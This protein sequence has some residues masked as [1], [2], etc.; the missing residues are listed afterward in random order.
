MWLGRSIQAHPLNILWHYATGYL[1]DFLNQR[2]GRVGWVRW[3]HRGIQRL[4]RLRMSRKQRACVFSDRFELRFNEAFGQVLRGCADTSRWG[5]RKHGGQT[6]MTP[7]LM[8]GLEE[9]H[10]LG[11]AHSFEAWQNGQL[12]GGIWGVQIGGLITMSSM[13]TTVSN[14]TRFAMGR[15][16]LCLRE[17]GFE[18][19]D[20]GMVPDHLVHF[21]AEW[22]PRWQYEAM[23]PR[24]LGQR[25]SLSEEIPCVRPPWR[26]RRGVE[27]VRVVRGVGRRMGISGFGSGVWG[28]G[29]GNMDGRRDRAALWTV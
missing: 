26:I 10:R 23:L 15:T 4:D 25:V 22:A 6:W 19:V 27:V 13:F 18:M 16:M 24:L 1:P 14:A 20:L 7:E 11:H 28:L 21:G 9:L 5:I 2:N 17:R 8:A 3:S 29:E 12:V